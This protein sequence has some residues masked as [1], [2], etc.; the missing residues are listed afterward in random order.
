MENS[1]IYD[2]KM[3]LFYN[4]KTEELLLFVHI[5]KMVLDASRTLADNVNLQF[6]NTIICGEVLQQVH[7]LCDKVGSTTMA[8]IKR[9]ILG[10]GTYFS[11]LNA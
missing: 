8:H 4:N 2:F 3:T 11:P 1:D 9:V 6:L 7:H 10:L 5:L